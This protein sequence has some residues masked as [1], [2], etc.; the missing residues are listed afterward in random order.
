MLAQLRHRRQPQDF[1]AGCRI[2]LGLCTLS[3]LTEAFEMMVEILLREETLTILLFIYKA[4]HS[5][6]RKGAKRYTRARA[7]EREPCTI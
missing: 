3:G 5:F 2:G 7:V 6:M 1:L 4:P